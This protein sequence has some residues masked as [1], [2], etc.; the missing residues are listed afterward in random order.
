MVFHTTIARNRAL[1]QAPRALEATDPAPPPPPQLHLSLIEDE[2]RVVN[3]AGDILAHIPV[4]PEE[5]MFGSRA[6]LV[7]APGGQRLVVG[8][9]FAHTVAP[10]AGSV[11][12]FDHADLIPAAGATE[13]VRIEPALATL[14]LDGAGDGSLLGAGLKMIPDVDADG[15]AD[16]L[17][18]APGDGL[19]YLLSGADG[20]VIRTLEGSRPE[21]FGA[22][23]AL[24][25]D[26]TGDGVREHLVASLFLDPAGNT[27]ARRWTFDGVSG[28]LVSVDET[29]DAPIARYA[30]DL[31]GDNAVTDADL[32]RV[33]LS[34]GAIAESGTLEDINGDAIV[35]ESDVNLVLRDYGEA[36]EPVGDLTAT[37]GLQHPC[38]WIW[39]YI[40]HP[41]ECAEYFGG[42]DGINPTGTG[43][44]DDPDG[45]GDGGSDGGGGSGGGSG[46]TNTGGGWDGSDG[47]TSGSG[48]GSCDGL[49]GPAPGALR[50]VDRGATYIFNQP[51]TPDTCTANW[52][53]EGGTATPINASLTIAEVVFGEVG[54]KIVSTGCTCQNAYIVSEMPIALD[55][56]AIPHPEADQP[57][58]HIVLVN[59]D[60]E[61]AEAGT[62]A[63]PEVLDFD[64]FVMSEVDDDLVPL[65]IG[66]PEH[67][68]NG[69][70]L[71]GTTR[72]RLDP[73]GVRVWYRKSDLDLHAHTDGP[74]GSP[75]MR[76]M[77]GEEYLVVPDAWI[78]HAV[79]EDL[80]LYV[81][82][83]EP[84]VTLGD[85]SVTYTLTATANWQVPGSQDLVEYSVGL[86]NQ[87]RITASQVDLS[88]GGEIS[89]DAEVTAASLVLEVGG[90]SSDELRTA[91]DGQ[92]VEFIVHRGG[93]EIA[94]STTQL[95]HGASGVAFAI[96][97]SVGTT[98]QV[99]AA[100]FG[101][102]IRGSAPYFTTPGA[103]A[104]F[105]F[106]PP[107]AALVADGVGTATVRV[108]A[109][110]RF[111]NLV[112][113]GTPLT[114]TVLDAAGEVVKEQS[115]D[116]FVGGAA[117]IVVRA[118]LS[119]PQERALR[120]HVASAPSA[121]ETTIP[122]ARVTGALS[123]TASSLDVWTGQSATLSLATNAA[124]GAPVFWVVEN[125]PLRTAESTVQN[126]VATLTVSAEDFGTGLS[127]VGPC[128]V[129]ASVADTLF[130]MPLE[131]ISSGPVGLSVERQ[132]VSGDM[133]EDGVA[134]VPVYEF[135]PI[136]G[137]PTLF[138]PTTRPVPYFASSDITVNGDPDG[139][140][141]VEL[142]DPTRHDPI[143]QLDSLNGGLLLLGADGT[144]VFTVR[145][146]GALP[147]G[148]LELVQIRVQRIDPL[149]F[150]SA[151]EEIVT[152][153]YTDHDVFTRTT[154][155]V[156][157]F[158]GGDPDTAAGIAAGVA[159]G[160]LV[161]GDVGAAGKNV[162]R[163]TGFSEK[164]PDYVEFGFASLGILST[165]APPL[166]PVAALVRS[167]S[168]ALGDT[169][170]V[171]LLVVTVQRLASTLDSVDIG[172]FT[173]FLR[174]VAR[175]VNYQIANDLFTSKQLL[176]DGVRAIN[177][178]WT[179]QAGDRS[180]VLFDKLRDI[181]G[182]APSGGVK[183]GQNVVSVLGDSSLSTRVLDDLTALD[184][185]ALGAAIGQLARAM[186][187]GGLTPAQIVR[188]LNKEH[189]K[190]YTTGFGRKEMIEALGVLGARAAESPEAK[191]GLSTVINRLSGAAFPN[192]VN[193]FRYELIVGKH[194][195]DL[196]T[197]GGSHFM[198][199]SV[200]P[201][202]TTAGRGTDIDT[203]LREGADG[204]SNAV[205]TFVQAKTSA[206]AID[207]N[208][209]V[210]WIQK[211]KDFAKH[212]GI[213]E[214][215]YN[216][217]YVTPDIDAIEAAGELSEE[218]LGL[219]VRNNVRRQSVPNP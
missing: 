84:S 13:P 198:T 94:R 157:S 216:I 161:V 139:L 69:R 159:G 39:Y 107:T 186:S 188:L 181:A 212:E 142:V 166:D 38:M 126:G 48:G 70:F 49:F 73:V 141:T 93:L 51:H 23:T 91:L 76:T 199:R 95:K 163:M 155:A 72:W 130:H 37:G 183:G 75:M 57:P 219:F 61:D 116:A 168:G 45:S 160:V 27:R 56:P 20:T 6:T 132:I 64:D 90:P 65:T 1:Q 67:I 16:V 35:D 119:V 204:S 133:L 74:A 92:N 83:I 41:E 147:A 117:E 153:V 113:D 192:S 2:F 52:Q 106:E 28:D 109:R 19:A 11:W 58:F 85:Q 210:A 96:G 98:I 82:A 50:I 114:A 143:V 9:P 197:F 205:Y 81:E 123:S 218:L 135:D 171:R 184:D 30:G 26:E 189:N 136:P 195:D 191:Q 211:I 173:T 111:G 89:L 175:S 149:G 100:V 179:E 167:L 101:A 131:F 152:V 12:W 112:E 150:G 32:T 172:R 154:D 127:H 99:D 215:Q 47:G 213:P 164:E 66:P 102:T 208:E 162:W 78:T 178:F 196:G 108:T 140:Y 138:T 151:E 79:T 15:A 5:G 14:V 10:S 170:F 68:G 25:R 80:T 63:D 177:R 42:G 77:A 97:Q 21:G 24:G 134:D 217:M 125:G 43:T 185:A 87:V 8:A 53:V 3:D 103:P 165:V 55:A 202:V 33:L 121:G 187:N 190:L 145:S 62:T 122:I 18:G 36:I 194:L 104:T 209:A 46:G 88:D 148:G 169:K 17:V 29:P 124:D 54:D 214:S 146:R 193:G 120:L 86:T 44:G 60:N 176:D 105:T 118:P 203:V 144:G 174:S 7:D 4:I 31:D 34:V 40:A 180:Q 22:A 158:F 59:N 201:K 137:A 206:A 110:D 128:R 115:D 129:F 207:A 156:T 71:Q 182:A 200:S